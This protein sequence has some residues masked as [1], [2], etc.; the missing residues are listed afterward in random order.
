[1]KVRLLRDIPVDKKFGLTKG[2]VVDVTYKVKPSGVE[3]FW[4]DCEGEDVKIFAQ[5]RET[6]E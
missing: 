6:I 5:E 4:V 1:M 2:K 3:G